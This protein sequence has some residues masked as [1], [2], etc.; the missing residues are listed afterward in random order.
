MY[1][2]WWLWRWC[3]WN[4]LQFKRMY[5]IRKIIYANER[6]LINLITMDL[7]FVYYAVIKLMSHLNN[8][9]YRKIL[10]QENH[11]RITLHEQEDSE[12][13]SCFIFLHSELIISKLTFPTDILEKFYSKCMKKNHGYVIRLVNWK[14]VTKEPIGSHGFKRSWWLINVTR[15]YCI[16]CK[17]WSLEMWLTIRNR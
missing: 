1:F 7:M 10:I 3:I 15:I 5:E 14:I 13:P 2:S 8:E 16:L 6:A 12:K 4:N 9:I 11:N 17:I